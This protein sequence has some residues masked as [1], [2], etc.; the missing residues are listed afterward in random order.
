MK[1]NYYIDKAIDFISYYLEQWESEPNFRSFIDSQIM[2]ANEAFVKSNFESY[3]KAW[4]YLGKD[5]SL[6]S[7]IYDEFFIEDKIDS[8]HRTNE[9]IIAHNEAII[10]GIKEKQ[11]EEQREEN[12]SLIGDNFN[13]DNRKKLSEYFN[14]LEI[15]NV[16]LF[17]YLIYDESKDEQRL[18]KSFEDAYSTYAKYSS[19]KLPSLIGLQV[20]I[21]CAITNW[22]INKVIGMSELDSKLEKLWNEYQT[23][24]GDQ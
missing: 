6:A 9:E 17:R 19:E 3:R 22:N 13:P 1:S 4:E 23:N 12:K 18:K 5:I 8:Y 15:S 24:R 7:E 11:F 10:E 20:E 21:Q 14:G 2:I 16:G